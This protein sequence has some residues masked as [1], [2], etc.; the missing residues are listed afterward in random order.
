MSSLDTGGV[1]FMAYPDDHEPRHVHGLIGGI[2]GPEVVVELSL[3]RTVCL[4]RRVDAVQGATRS[5]V[6]KVLAAAADRFDDLIALWDS[7]H[8]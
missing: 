5:E 3:D 7:M 8:Q 2:G 6:R 4:A 1:K